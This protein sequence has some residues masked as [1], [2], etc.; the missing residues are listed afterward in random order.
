V[1]FHEAKDGAVSAK[2]ERRGSWRGG[3]ELEED[4]V[5]FSSGYASDPELDGAAHV[6]V[7]LVAYLHALVGVEVAVRANEDARGVNLVV[8]PLAALWHGAHDA[9]S[10][11]IYLGSEVLRVRISKEL[12]N[13]TYA[14]HG[15]FQRK[16]NRST[17]QS[18]F[19]LFLFQINLFEKKKIFNYY[20]LIRIILITFLKKLMDGFVSHNSTSGVLVLR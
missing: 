11:G 20:F 6:R 8:D 16:K 7:E 9:L 1:P 15:C 2:I 5:S 13:T 19:P 14:S 18:F 12:A 3:I 10:D 4:D 17:L